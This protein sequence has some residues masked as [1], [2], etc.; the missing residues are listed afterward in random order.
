M[1]S[2]STRNRYWKAA[3]FGP[4]FTVLLTVAVPVNL[5]PVGGPGSLVREIWLN[6][7][8]VLARPTA[9]LP[10]AAPVPAGMPGA[11]AVWR[12]P[13]NLLSAGVLS[14]AALGL[15]RFMGAAALLRRRLRGRRRVRDLR[16]LQALER[17]RTGFALPAVRLTE[18]AIIDSP[19][20]IGRGEICV[21][22]PLL[23]G[24]CDAEVESVLAHELAHLER[25]DGL[26]FPIITLVQAVLWWQPLNHWLA[27]RL[28]HT[29]EL[30]CDDR[31]V[32]ITGNPLD[33]A[34]ALV[35]VA[36]GVLAARQ[37]AMVPTMARSTSALVPRVA[38]LI[39]LPP[40]AAGEEQAGGR[41][42]LWATAI[43]ALVGLAM[44]G[45]RVQVAQ[46]RPGRPGI[47]RAVVP[48][49]RPDAAAQSAQLAA[50]AQREEQLE[51]A[52]N[53]T[54]AGDSDAAASAQV[55][56]WQQDLRHVRAMEI[57]LESQFL[58]QW[59]S[60]EKSRGNT[61]GAPR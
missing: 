38:R 61:A 16:L 39:T 53:F 37:P 11:G 50:L 43:I 14:A 29:A 41:R 44:T 47:D 19:L 6:A 30:A 51:A 20:V 49:A 56:Q 58:D 60:W 45:L 36:T 40:A 46:A 8:T 2:S 24:L 27:A 59:A 15:L 34:R 22:L 33:L 26:W 57:W 35:Q 1:L 10:T 32:A 55:L 17:M 9:R 42:R 23:T 5:S 3:L 21:P 54:S 7:D 28:R 4:L 25:G 48:P 31:A 18:T 13:A 12:R 52:I